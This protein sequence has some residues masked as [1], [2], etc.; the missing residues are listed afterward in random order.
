MNSSQ[1]ILIATLMREQGE[2]GVQTYFNMLRDYLVQIGRKTAIITPFSYFSWLVIPVF[3]LRK[4]IDPL[5]G[6]WSV[7]WYR[8]W[9][10][11]FL[12][13]L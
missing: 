5:N 2:T 7:G 4:L 13:R 11:F 12:S 8:Y 3:A 9:H 1:P 6:E 10:Y